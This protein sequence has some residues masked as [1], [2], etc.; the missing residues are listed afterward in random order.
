MP[1]LVDHEHRKLEIAQATWR[2]IKILG[3]ENLTLRDIA[4]EAGFTTGVFSH[5]FKDKNSVLRYA[6]NIA[7]RNAYDRIIKANEDIPDG[8]M[9]IRNV[10]VEILPDARRPE[11][12]AFVSLCFGIRNSKDPLLAKEYKVKMAEL[13]ELFNLY[14]LDVLNKDE[15]HIQKTPEELIDLFAAV[16]DG[17][18]IQALLN[19][20]IYT[21]KRCIRTIENLIEELS[22]KP[23]TNS[24]SC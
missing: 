12:I 19:P 11:S 1:K 23:T 2:A 21:R 10:L 22:Y 20:K 6:F 9:R 7:Y 8:F 5:Y 15:I 17:L 24:A 14:T 4:V 16:L 18:C 13:R 3:I